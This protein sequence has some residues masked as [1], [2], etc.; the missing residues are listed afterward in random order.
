MVEK[1]FGHDLASARHLNAAIN[2]VF[3]EPQVYRIDHYL[4]K[5]TVQNVLAFRFANILFEPVWNR[6]YVDQVQITVAESLGVENRA[7]YY[8]EAGALRDMVQ[9]HILQLLA[10]VAME[11]P[12][13]F[14]GD[15]LRDEKVKVLRS[16]VPPAGDRV[17]ES[18]VRGQYAAGFVSGSAV[19]GYR[20]EE[21]I[22][23]D[24]RTETF[25]ALKLQIDNWRWNGGT[26]IDWRTPADKYRWLPWRLTGRMAA[27]MT[28]LP[29]LRCIVFLPDS[30]SSLRSGLDR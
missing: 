27:V 12:A 26:L 5:E 25:V 28:S 18:V 30:F 14:N 11:P 13:F 24:S 8:E 16:V 7:A 17:S 1:P 15:A 21:G 23:P 22:K 6:H 19:P 29:S 20:D 9:S 4:G 2:N 3:S 10:V